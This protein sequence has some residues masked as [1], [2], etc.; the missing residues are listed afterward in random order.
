MRF[1]FRLGATS[2]I[3]PAD[4]LAN[5]A[6]LADK[7][8]DVELVLFDLDDGQSNLPSAS[9]AAGLR[10]LALER[11]L[12][13]TVHLPLDLRMAQDGSP[14]HPSLD[15]ARRVIDCTRV[16]EPWAY[17]AHLDGRSVLPAGT[18]PADRLRWQDHS[19]Q[20]LQ[21]VGE[22]IGDLQKLALENLE[23][24]PLAFHAEIL[25]RIAVSQTVDIGHL[26]LDGY[27]PLAYLRAAL[28]RTR[29]IHIHGIAERDHSSLTY[30]PRASL[31]AVL[32]ELERCNYS[33]VL[34]LEIFSE[35]DL[36]SSLQVLQDLKN[37]FPELPEPG[38]QTKNY[39]SQA[40]N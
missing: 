24:Y 14:R 18:T 26:W 15:K 20:A 16:L 33:G 11:G 34:T 31:A 3:I 30:A 13:F 19:V 6:Y 12:S 17:V 7:V 39:S 23:G 4:L 22:W 2:Y 32:A 36:L 28:P 37:C 29:V 40:E 38:K 21:L 5:A 27:D 35:Q 25:A 1:P 8:Q 10:K 9:Q